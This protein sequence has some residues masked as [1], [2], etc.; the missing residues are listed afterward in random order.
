[1]VFEEFRD[2]FS[3]FGFVAKFVVG[4]WRQASLLIRA[5]LCN[6]VDMASAADDT[7]TL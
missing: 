3:R 1:M 7:G 5:V 4:R 2:I 6:A